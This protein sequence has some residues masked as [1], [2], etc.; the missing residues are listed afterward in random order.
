VRVPWDD[1]LPGT[2]EALSA[3]DPQTR[4][5]YT[6]LAGVLVAGMDSRSVSREGSVHRESPVPGRSPGGHSD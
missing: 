5:A 3:L 4:H 6:A 2:P 1:Q